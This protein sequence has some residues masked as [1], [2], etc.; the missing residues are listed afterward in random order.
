MVTAC[1]LT[2]CCCCFC[3]C[4]CCN[5]CCGKWKPSADDDDDYAYDIDISAEDDAEEPTFTNAA[6]DVSSYVLLLY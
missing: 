2:G 4:C 6:F 5:C 3:C 1:L